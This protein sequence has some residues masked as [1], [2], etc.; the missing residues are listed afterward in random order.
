M[1]NFIYFALTLAI[2]VVALFCIQFSFKTFE[3]FDISMEPTYKAG[4]FIL[5]NKLDYIWDTPKREM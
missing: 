4:D 5:V 3:V 2:A 1:K